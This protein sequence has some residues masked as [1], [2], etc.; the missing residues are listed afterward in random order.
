MR[1]MMTRDEAIRAAGLEAVERIERENCEP[2][3]VVGYNGSCQGDDE[4]EW[5][6]SVTCAAGALIAYYYTTREMDDAI[7]AADGD[8]GAI[9]W[10]VAG[11]ELI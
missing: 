11:Y 4:T 8:G 2:T 6:A 5:S 3:N 1:T 9:N 10:T 7:A